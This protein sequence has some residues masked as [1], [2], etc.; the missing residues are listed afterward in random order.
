MIYLCFVVLPIIA[1]LW[2]FNLALL[3]K[4]LHQGRDIHNETVLGTVYTAIFVF[5]FMYVWIGMS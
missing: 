2:F 5:F 1:G 4:K 3:L